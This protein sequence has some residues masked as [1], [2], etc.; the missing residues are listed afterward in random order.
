MPFFH[1]SKKIFF[2]Y[3]KVQKQPF[4]NV[5]E[6]SVLESLRPAT[7]LKK[8]HRCFPANIAKFLRT[9]SLEDLLWLLLKVGNSVLYIYVMYCFPSLLK[10]FF[11]QQ[12]HIIF[13]I[14]AC[15]NNIYLLRDVSILKSLTSLKILKKKY[16][17]GKE[18]CINRSLFIYGVFVYFT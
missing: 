18:T 17:I 12:K 13:K 11:L 8:R 6:T 5:L 2:Q 7:L 9:T 16:V 3:S 15:C 4:A 10:C 14:L 1:F